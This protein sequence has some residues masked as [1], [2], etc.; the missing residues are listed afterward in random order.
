MSNKQIRFTSES[1]NP[2]FNKSSVGFDHLLESLFGEVSSTPAGGYPPYN[3][4]RTISSDN[5]DRY[6]IVLA[7]AGFTEDDIDIMVE[8]SNLLISG[9]SDALGGESDLVE[10]LHKGIAARK[11][12]RSF[13][14][15]DDVIVE[16]ASLK[17]GI[18]TVSLTR[19]VPDEAIP[20]SIK[21]NT[22]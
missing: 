12:T 20:Q 18:L 2:L 14:L 19:I 1:L 11:F 13:K 8:N 9:N 3:I 6:N 5:L 22:L 15:A 4:T 7:L 21:I 17:N 10:Y 16:T